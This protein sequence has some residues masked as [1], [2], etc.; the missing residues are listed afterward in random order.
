MN[1]KNVLHLLRVERKSG[2]LIRGVKTT[3][4]REHGVL[5][6]WPYWLAA[7]IGIGV[8]LLA[9]MAVQAVY[10]GVAALPGLPPLSDA[11]MGF[12]ASMPTLILILSLVFTM[13]QQIQTAGLKKTSQV[14]Y[15]LPVTWQEHTLASVLSNLFGLPIALVVGFSAGII[16]FSA[17]NGLIV[18]ALLAAL[19][20]CA[21]AFIGSATTEIARILQVRFTGAVY[22][23]SGRAAIWV[24]L[25][26]SLIFFVALYIVWFALFTGTGSISFIQT[27]ASFQISLWFIPFVWPGIALYYLFVSDFLVGAFFVAATAA[28]MAALFYIA[29]KLNTRFGLYEPPAIK[30]QV[31][32]VYTAKTGLLGRIGFSTVEA[33]IIRKDIRSFTRRREL[34]GIFIIPI[35]FIIVPIFNSINISNAGDGAP[36]ELSIFFQA[37]IFL[38]PAAIMAMTLG[39]MLIGEE[40]QAV[41][42][43]YA[44]PI[45]AKNLVKAKYAFLIF[46]STVIL[47]ITGAVGIVFF[48]PNLTM[49][50][51]SFAEAMFLVFAL[52]AIG[53]TFGFKGADFTAARRA[54][55]IRQEWSLISFVV[56]LLAGLAI[57]AP[58][59]PYVLSE[60]A[61]SFIP[62]PWTIGPVEL[63]ISIFISGVIAAVFTA[64]FYRIN[65]DSAKELIRKAEI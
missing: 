10:S 1:W 61:S 48:H 53:L 51:M 27:I 63:A 25:I 34:I 14:M 30:V 19:A 18:G 5:A 13:F 4:Y 45:S 38:F 29:V 46:L 65:L 54:R 7:I 62:I 43:I 58:L 6:Y 41:W 64:V 2:R 8:G 47:I 32:G 36:P 11:A 12:F 39:N 20:M 40:G 17:F 21:A 56:C 9:N 26:G 16:V 35:V 23:S 31:S 44:S 55:M 15:W 50:I 59:V 28:F 33:A 57:L 60:F 52:G 42:R 22:K 37:M 3:H 24:R 49:A